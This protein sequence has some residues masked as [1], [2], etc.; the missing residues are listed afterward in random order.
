MKI[1]ILWLPLALVIASCGDI[2]NSEQDLISKE[3]ALT[4]TQIMERSEKRKKVPDM[5]MLLRV[6]L[7]SEPSKR[8]IIDY[9]NSIFI[10]SRNQESYD[11]G[12]PQILML[13][14]VGSESM[15]LLLSA[16]KDGRKQGLYGLEAIRLLADVHSK[17]FILK[18]LRTHPF[19][20]KVIWDKE[21][22]ADAESI[23]VSFVSAGY[24]A[25]HGYY[26]M[27]KCLDGLKNP[28]YYPLLRKALA[29]SWDPYHVLL[30]LTHTPDTEFVDELREAW[31][32]KRERG[33]QYMTEEALETGYLPAF[34][35]LW[36]VFDNEE[37]SDYDQ[38]HARRL[39]VRFSD[40]D[41]AENELMNWYQINKN[42]IEFDSTAKKF[43]LAK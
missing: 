22:C 1:T 27:I 21:W 37:I 4:Q 26:D 5:D 18:N 17:D 29:E 28:E 24:G 15:N 8:E 23:L 38:R 9:I 33:V 25:N 3:D 30:A 34:H 42:Q 43:V 31:A 10:L 39:L 41:I 20:A 14:L 13:T 36:D 6:Q 11:K 32:R 40:F 12:D 7:P 2:S 16:S 35:Y 19:L